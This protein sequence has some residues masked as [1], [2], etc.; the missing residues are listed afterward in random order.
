[1]VL[2]PN[3]PTP[4]EVALTPRF[5]KDLRT[6]VKRYRRIRSDLQP[7]IQQL[8][9]GELPGDQI[10]GMQ[11][12]LFK[13]RLRNSDIQKGKS[14]GYRVIYYVQTQTQI[15][16]VTMYS[17]SDQADVDMNTITAA[18]AQYDQDFE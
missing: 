12:T 1:M 14:G 16:L 17:K 5:K 10:P 6:L 18:L 7:L 15:I 2:M 3:E 13:V 4:V 9:A 8:E 11:L